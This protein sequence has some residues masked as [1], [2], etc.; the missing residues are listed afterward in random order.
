VG[1][2]GKRILAKGEMLLA[3]KNSPRVL[4]VL[5]KAFK[6]KGHC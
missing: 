4:L 6:V 3:N 5:E 1:G 2:L